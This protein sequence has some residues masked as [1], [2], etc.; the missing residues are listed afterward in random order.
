MFSVRAGPTAEIHF[1]LF[2]Q[3]I[4]LPRKSRD[5]ALARLAEEYAGRL[6]HFCRRAPL[7]WFN[8]YDFWSLSSVEN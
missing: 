2:R 3:S 5:Q 4:R 8:F 6:E 7:Q 1:E